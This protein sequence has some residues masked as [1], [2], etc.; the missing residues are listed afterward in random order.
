MRDVE[1]S[2]ALKPG[3]L[4]SYILTPVFPAYFVCDQVEIATIDGR[5][6]RRRRLVRWQD[7]DASSIGVDD[8]RGELPDVELPIDFRYLESTPVLF[9]HYWMP[10]EPTITCSAAAC[11]DFSVAKE[12]Y[13]TAYRWSGESELSSEHLVYVP[14]KDPG[15]D[16]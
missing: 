7:L 13:L 2:V 10:G 1:P 3:G 14:A 4:P 15:D 8:I 16:T 12:G 6:V 9:G 11:L 5:S